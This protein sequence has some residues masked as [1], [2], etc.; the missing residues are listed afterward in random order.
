MKGYS[1]WKKVEST[2]W[3]VT[4]ISRISTFSGIWEDER[5]RKG[6]WYG[7][8]QRGGGRGGSRGGNGTHA[9][10]WLWW[11]WWLWWLCTLR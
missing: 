1:Y 8:L 2:P 9:R 10:R 11:L 7:E 3:K 5:E 6:D 4:M